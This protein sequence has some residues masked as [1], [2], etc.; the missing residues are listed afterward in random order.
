MD[1]RLAEQLARD[2]ETV[3]MI[4]CRGL[5]D[6]D[7]P[8]MTADRF[9]AKASRWKKYQACVNCKANS[10]MTAKIASY[11]VVYLEQYLDSDDREWATGLAGTVNRHNWM[12]FELDN[13]PIGR[14]ST[15]LSLN[16]HKLPDVTL[17]DLAWSE[18]K[19]DLLNSL[20]T[21][22]IVPRILEEFRPDHAV[23]YDPLYPTNRMFAI[24][25]ERFGAKFIG[26]TAGAF[27]PSRYE[28]AVMYPHISS[29]QTKVESQAVNWGLTQ[30]LSMTEVSS[31]GR[32][33]R[34]LMSATDPW[35]YSSA[36]AAINHESLRS[37]LD[38]SSDSPVA[39]V[40]L[41][42][43]DETRSSVMVDAE[44]ARNGNSSAPDILE[45]ISLVA[46]TASANPDVHF[47][48]RVHPRLYSNKRDKFVSPD[49]IQ[50]LE[51]LDR[52]PVN[53][54]I[55]SPDQNISL[56]ELIGLSSVAINQS[57]SAGLEFL[58]LGVPVI[59][60]DP[61]LQGN[62]PPT[63][64]FSI[65]AHDPKI[66]S[67]SIRLA[68]AR[69]PS[70]DY[71][72]A[73]FRWYAVTLMRTVTP[74]GDVFEI[75]RGVD[76]ILEGDQNLE[77]T[78]RSRVSYKSVIPAVVREFGAQWIDRRNRV[79][80]IPDPEIDAGWV[81]ELKH[82]IAAANQ[83]IIWEPLLIQR[84]T[85]LAED[86]EEFIRKEVNSLRAVVGAPELP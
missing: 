19:A 48:F 14:Y 70:I 26:L 83:G 59:H 9:T 15:Y 37:R 33:L 72:L 3:T 52:L 79:S 75:E 22:R 39:V 41:S 44:F 18:Y 35:V 12:N 78:S 20:Y 66:L 31:V 24:A 13:I 82:R 85:P 43:P 74:L 5:F 71:S 42:S 34:S 67:E 49:A 17:S 38:I 80:D 25:S 64:G 2:G 40:L 45:F 1:H 63:F 73:A 51:A 6:T 10:S 7:C 36:I 86:E 4:H 8:V 28:T 81:S 58:S 84:G 61:D 47:V 62:Y 21:L 16:R 32:Y 56:Y 65:S 68:I 57:S 30:S 77:T 27:V 29:N 60:C 46:Q 54:S 53:A 23:V 69:G 11:N 76:A 55:N 50:I